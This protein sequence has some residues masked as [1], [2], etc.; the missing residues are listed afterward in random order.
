MLLWHASELHTHT[1]HSDGQYTVAELLANS[2]EAGYETVA[3]TDHNTTSGLAELPA[4]ARQTGLHV[5][6]GIEWSSYYGHMV[7][8]G[9]RYYIPWHDIGLDDIHKGIAL[10]HE[11]GGITG[12]AH[13]FTIGEPFCLGCHWHFRVTDWN[14]PD[15]IEVWNECWPSLEYSNIKAFNFW[16]EKLNEGYRIYAASGRDWHGA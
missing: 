12:I 8:H 7:T 9:A 11:A 15:Y 10:V 6:R 3:L 14:H 4:A 5:I 1:L 16:T 13:P 2:V